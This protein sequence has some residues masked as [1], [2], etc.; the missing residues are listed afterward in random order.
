MTSNWL[1]WILA[2]FMLALAALGTRVVL[3][4]YRRHPTSPAPWPGDFRRALLVVLVAAQGSML[5]QFLAYLTGYT[6]LLLDLALCLFMVLLCP[7]ILVRASVLYFRGGDVTDNGRT[8]EGDAELCSAAPAG[9][10]TLREEVKQCA[11]RYKERFVSFK[12]CVTNYKESFVSFVGLYLWAFAI[13]VSVGSLLDSGISTYVAPN[14]VYSP[15][16]Q[17]GHQPIVASNS[18]IKTLSEFL[19]RPEFPH[20]ILPVGEDVLT[21]P[22]RQEGVSS[23]CVFVDDYFQIILYCAFYLPLLVYVVLQSWRLREQIIRIYGA[24]GQHNGSTTEVHQYRTETEV[25]NQSREPCTS[26]GSDMLHKKPDD[27]KTLPEKDLKPVPGNN[28]TKTAP[29]SQGARAVVCFSPNSPK[30]DAQAA[31]CLSH[32][33]TG[34]ESESLEAGRGDNCRVCMMVAPYLPLATL[35]VLVQ[36]VL[37]VPVCAA[38]HWTYSQQV[39]HVQSLAL[40]STVYC[41]LCFAFHGAFRNTL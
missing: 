9:K 22:P 32:T 10:E 16:E 13:C 11:T 24:E 23:V 35:V 18:E 34:E 30:E 33:K 4:L 39:M 15:E 31:V 14:H 2:S 36:N 26:A 1:R 25:H 40:Y 17:Y 8:M 37:L 19:E 6:F 20:P 27:S 12:W 38:L 41:A 29:A 21:S 28:D 7:L 5:L 3:H